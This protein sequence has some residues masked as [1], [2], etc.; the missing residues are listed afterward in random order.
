MNPNKKVEK[1][2]NNSNIFFCEYCNYECFRKEHFNKH[3]LTSK[4]KKMENSKK[5]LINPNEKVEK[6]E[7]L[8]NNKFVCI[9]GK[10]YKHKSSL[11]A[12]KKTC[13][14]EEPVCEEIQKFQPESNEL[15]VKLLEK[16]EEKDKL[17]LNVVD[18]NTELAKE[19][20]ELTKKMV[21]IA[22][23][24]GNNNNNTINNNQRINVNVFLNEECKNALN[25][26]DFLKSIEVSFEQLD[27]TKRHGLE[28][29]ITKVIMD[30]LN[31]L[32]KYERPLHCTDTKRKTLYIKE[33]DK[34]EKDVDKSQIKK[35]INKTS[36]KNYTALINWRDSNPDWLERDDKS[37]Y[38]A[39]AMSKLGK[40]IE[41]VE[42]KII[43]NIC[44]GNYIKNEDEDEFV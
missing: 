15:V 42:E 8:E 2:E 22:P 4:H 18:K 12:H 23:N 10:S 24:I 34:W 29:G 9:C 11:C 21:E 35:A 19:N 3:L 13:N 20:S 6:V 31:K 33:N 1:V 25:M 39:K 7:N 26:S 43:K 30:N 16:M 38:Y 41:D 14:Y 36:N 32:S 40:P 28:Q 17:L 44:V 37:I 5:I 27:L